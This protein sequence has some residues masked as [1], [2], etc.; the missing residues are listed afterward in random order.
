MKVL[1]AVSNEEISENIVKKYQREYK[2]IISYKNVYYF[3]AILKELQK[4]KTYDR[5]VI[6]EDLENFTSNQYDQI[7]KF[8]FEKL[9]SISDEASNYQGDNIPIILICADRRTKSE[10]MLIKLFGISIYDA[11]LGPDRNIDELCKLINKPRSKKEAKIYYKIDSEDVNYKP[12]NENDVSEVEIQNILAHYKRLGKNEEKYLESFDN[13]ASQYNDVQLR[14][15]CKFLPLNVR[16]VLEEKSPKYQ[17]VMSFNSKVTDK[18]RKGKH[19]EEANGTSEKLLKTVN[20]KETLLSKPVVIPNAV[21]LQNTKKLTKPKPVEENKEEEDPLKQI[22]REINTYVKNENGFVQTQQ[23]KTTK[24]E[25]NLR[26]AET[27]EK[28]EEVESKPAPKRGRGRPRKNPLPEEDAPKKKRGRPKKNTEDENQLQ[29][30]DEEDL[31]MPGIEETTKQEENL[32]MPG[33]EEEQ[34]ENIIMPGL[35]EKA[36]ELGMKETIE[37]KENE[38]RPINT[39]GQISKT[40]QTINTEID[41]SSLLTGNKKLACFVGTS[42]NGTSFIVNNVAQILSTHGISTAILDLTQNRN[43]YYV[44]TNNIEDLRNTAIYCFQNLI[45]GNPKGIQANKNLTVYTSL[46]DDNEI[47]ENAGEI[48]QT[49]VKNYS[50]VLIDCDFKTP[51]SY[52]SYAQEIYL[53]QSMDV[54]TIQPLTSFLNELRSKNILDEKKLRIILNKVEK[55]KK[56]SEKV[57]IGGM[58]SYNDPAMT[59]MVELFDKNLIKYISI[60]FDEQVYVKYLDGLIDCEISLKGYPKNIIQ[61]LTELANMIYKNT[62]GTTSYRP[63][64]VNGNG[65]SPSINSTLEQMRKY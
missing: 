33:L 6:S 46:P 13:I 53:V 32:V 31:I 18:L 2:E 48:L 34:E 59:Y 28:T 45:N 41:I 19:N 26:I 15:I 57:I 64:T 42:K 5:I 61:I 51:L 63:P 4:D 65:F 60:P 16:A 20:T 43:S 17:K 52:F 3:N 25:E 58:S 40:E 7:D 27:E 47:I 24:Q 10:Q 22:E 8:I 30:Q 55:L 38:I 12:E 54:L 14:I 11:L 50:V 21:N 29:I 56:A 37:P 23:T 49:L 44:Y 36:E 1:F 62:A 35:E 39:I 9:D